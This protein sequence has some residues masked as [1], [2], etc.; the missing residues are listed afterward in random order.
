M[1][2]AC[3]QRP[4]QMQHFPRIREENEVSH[5]GCMGLEAHSQEVMLMDTI[6]PEEVARRIEK[7]GYTEEAERIERIYTEV[8]LYSQNL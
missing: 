1:S 7:L 3:L 8:P 5:E 4:R 2:S 6:S